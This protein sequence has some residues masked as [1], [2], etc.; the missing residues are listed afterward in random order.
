MKIGGDAERL[1][2]LRDL[3]ELREELPKPIRILG[4][5]SN[6][7]IDDRGLKG[8]VIVVRDFGA[9]EPQIL[10]ESADEVE[11]RLSAG[12]YLPT[13]AR[14]TSRRGL[15]GCEYMIGIPGTVGGAL[16]QNAGANQQEFNFILVDAEFF[17]F[18]TQMLETWSKEQCALTYRHSALKSRADL[19]A[20]SVRVRLKRDEVNSIESR[21]EMN[22]N[23]RKDKTP[24]SKPSLGS[25][26][27]RLEHAGG[28]LYP[29]QLIEVSGLKGHR[30]GGAQVSNVHANYIV[31]E[32]NATFDDV[33]ALM[34]HIER[35]V[36][37]VQGVKLVREILV[38]S[39]R[40]EI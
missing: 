19:L 22:L 3:K 18:K 17:N 8:T 14:W 2:Q 40:D 32:A 15:T 28:W 36:F 30:V 11:M 27:T 6:I 16:V 12:F 4:N 39:D 37:E 7:L 34:K 29:G 21:I 38:W 35:V 33:I 25:V 23:Y 26:Y 1:V 31:N 20:T 5:G 13:L 10:S 24:Y 9:L